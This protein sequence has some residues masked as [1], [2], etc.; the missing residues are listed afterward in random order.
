M[1]GQHSYKQS[2]RQ[3]ARSQARM[4]PRESFQEDFVYLF[5]FPNVSNTGTQKPFLPSCFQSHICQC[6]YFDSINPVQLTLTE[7][8]EIK[9]LDCATPNLVI[10]QS[11]STKQT[12]VRQYNP[13]I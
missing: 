1:L 2:E 10:S 9:N 12:S 5:T 13:A 3:W 11:S 7:K 6:E 8:T 4:Q